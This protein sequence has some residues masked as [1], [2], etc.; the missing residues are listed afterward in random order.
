MPS[1][2]G[3]GSMLLQNK[4]LPVESRC[5]ANQFRCN[6]GLCIPASWQCDGDKDCSDHTDE[7]ECIGESGGG[8]V[9]P[10]LVLDL[11]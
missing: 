9:C 3:K 2:M 1:V 8:G 11:K 7:L 4:T 5:D 10:C 6:D